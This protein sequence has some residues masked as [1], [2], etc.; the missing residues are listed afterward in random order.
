MKDNV[1]IYFSN[2]ENLLD[3]YHFEPH[4][5]FNCDESGLSCVHKPLKVISSTGKRCVSS[6]T[7]GEK[8]VTTTILYLMKFSLNTITKKESEILQQPELTTLELMSHDKLKPIESFLE[9]T[10]TRKK[11]KNNKKKKL[12]E[13]NNEN[14]FKKI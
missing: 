12:L 14:K 8:G 1:K 5:I 13:K 2:L 3:K 9:T 11:K 7:S 4:Q 10:A 6:V